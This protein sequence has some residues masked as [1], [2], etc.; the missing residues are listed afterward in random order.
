MTPLRSVV[1]LREVRKKNT[2]KGDW[3]IGKHAKVT[4]FVFIIYYFV[5]ECVCVRYLVKYVCLKCV[6]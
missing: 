5:Y 1:M 3:I 4:P 2:P 6:F